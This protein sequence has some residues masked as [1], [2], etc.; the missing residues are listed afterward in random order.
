MLNMLRTS[1]NLMHNEL[2]N[3]HIKSKCNI[4]HVDCR[5]VTVNLEFEINGKR[6]LIQKLFNQYSCYDMD[7]T[8][9][10]IISLF[11]TELWKELYDLK[12]EEQIK[13]NKILL[14]TN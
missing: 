7:K 1:L 2:T 9:T 4:S 12:S 11:I 13:L 5:L 14:C 8:S 6:H 10:H 3:L